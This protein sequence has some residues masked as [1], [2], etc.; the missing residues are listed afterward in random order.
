MST[1]RRDGEE[2]VFVGTSPHPLRWLYHE[3]VAIQDL[4]RPDIA[5]HTLGRPS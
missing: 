3:A 2:S 5:I 1:K 4:K